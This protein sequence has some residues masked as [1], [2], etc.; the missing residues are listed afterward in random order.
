VVELPG[1]T[2]VDDGVP[3]PALASPDSAAVEGAA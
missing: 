2:A 3:D 1:P